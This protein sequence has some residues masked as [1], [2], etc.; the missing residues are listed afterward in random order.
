MHCKCSIHCIEDH[1]VK[2]PFNGLIRKEDIRDIEKGTVE[3]WKC[4]RPGDIVLARVIGIGEGGAFLLST[5]EDEFGVAVA[6]SS[7]SMFLVV[8]LP[9][10]ILFFFR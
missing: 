4:F 8:E 5:A 2:H 7:M 10:L 6:Y 1:V 9:K 3:I